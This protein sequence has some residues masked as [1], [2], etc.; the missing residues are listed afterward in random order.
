LP[1]MDLEAESV[2]SYCTEVGGIGPRGGQDHCC[3]V[4]CQWTAL[5]YQL[6]FAVLKFRLTGSTCQ[7]KLRLNRRSKVRHGMMLVPHRVSVC[8]TAPYAPSTPPSPMHC[9]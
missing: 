5:G 9:N 1:A 6:R 8:P 7:W 3:R 2:G 4:G